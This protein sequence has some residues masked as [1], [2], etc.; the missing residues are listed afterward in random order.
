MSKRWATGWRADA[1]LLALLGV[2]LVINPAGYVGRGADDYQYVEAARCW[3]AQGP[4]LPTDHWEAR[5]PLVAPMAALFALLGENRWVAGIVPLAASLGAVLVLR[6]IGDRLFGAPA[7]LVGAS[8]LVIA[9]VMSARLLVPAVEPIELLLISLGALWLLQRRWWRAGL[10]LGLALQTRETGLFLVIALGAL[11]TLTPLMRRHIAPAVGTLSGL[12]LPFLVEFIGFALATGDPLYRRLL[13]TGHGGIASTETDMVLG[14]GALPFF[15]RALIESWRHEGPVA[16]HPLIDGPLN[17]LIHP[18]T[19]FLLLLMVTG[20]IAIRWIGTPEQRRTLTRLVLLTLGHIL[21]LTYVLAI[22]PKPRMMLP[23]L[24]LAA[25]SGGAMLAALG[26]AT[27]PLWPTFVFACI[28]LPALVALSEHR[29][30]HAVEAEVARWRA[31]T[32]ARVEAPDFL[33]EGLTFLDGGAPEPLASDSPYLLLSVGGRCAP[34]EAAPGMD[35]RLRTVAA[36]EQNFW[37][38]FNSGRGGQ[39]CIFAQKADVAPGEVEALFAPDP[40]ALIR[41]KR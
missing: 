13:S 2:L 1:A 31:A 28:A 11:F 14:D 3:V 15:N 26:R 32:G 33:R 40:S 24:A 34:F 36:F 9:P 8:L 17:L 37:G 4:C 29:R 38:R 39:L 21:F 35:G 12:A 16:L 23:A 7:G 19:G 27:R 18:W 5:W 41:P 6:R 10:A 22:D 30:Y 20:W 25:L